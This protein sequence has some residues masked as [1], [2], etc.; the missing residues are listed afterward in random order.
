M[1]VCVQ[2]IVLMVVLFYC[3]LRPRKEEILVNFNISN[4]GKHPD[5]CDTADYFI[6]HLLNRTSA[7]TYTI[8]SSQLY[9]PKSHF[10]PKSHKKVLSKFNIRTT[11]P[12]HRI[13]KTLLLLWDPPREGSLSI[14]IINTVTQS[15]YERVK[16]S[17]DFLIDVNL[18]LI[19]IE[20]GYF[21]L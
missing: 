9:P 8:P 7:Y 2:V 3:C 6:S 19:S 1:Y 15:F 16:I 12:P 5:T 13:R 11:Y 10:L 17:D 14:N 18:H 21:R 20:D 4:G